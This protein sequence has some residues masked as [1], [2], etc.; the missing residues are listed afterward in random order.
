VQQLAAQI[1]W[2]HNCVL[3]DK[4]KDPIE[5]EWYARKT[6]ENGWS[7]AVLVHQIEL[8]LYARQAIAKKSH[9][10][11]K[12]LPPPDSDLVAEMLKD[13]YIFDFLVLG[14]DYKERDGASFFG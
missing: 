3:L 14:D 10:F 9:N 12:T 7:R 6:L 11:D 4:I 13:E 2:F 5:R 8:Q 1:P